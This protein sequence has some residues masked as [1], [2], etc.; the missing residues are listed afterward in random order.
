[1]QKIAIN[2]SRSYDSGFILSERAIE[3]LTER[4]DID[5]VIWSIPPSIYPEYR[6]KHYFQGK[7]KQQRSHPLLISMIEELG[8]DI[9]SEYDSNIQIVEIPD[10]VEWFIDSDENGYEWVKEKSRSWYYKEKRLYPSAD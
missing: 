6:V 9:V 1:M 10:G 7:G 3:Y 8:S 5:E 2:T 4:C